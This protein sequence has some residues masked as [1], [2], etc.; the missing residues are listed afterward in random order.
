MRTRFVGKVLH[1]MSENQ[2]ADRPGGRLH[3]FGPSDWLNWLKAGYLPMQSGTPL[4]YPFAQF[5]RWQLERQQQR[6]VSEEAM[7][8]EWQR[9][10]EA[11]PE[12]VRG[13]LSFEHFR[14]QGGSIEADIRAA[15]RRHQGGE[16]P[17]YDNGWQGQGR[18]LRLFASPVCYAGWR[19]LAQGFSGLAVALNSAHKSLA[20]TKER[21]SLLAPVRY[22]QAHRFK[23]SADN[24]FPGLLE[25]HAS[26]A[27][28]QEWRL[29]MP[30]KTTPQHRDKPALPLARDLVRAIYWSVAT[31]DEVV[32]G[33]RALKRDMRFRSVELGCITPDAHRWQLQ[34]DPD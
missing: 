2:Q 15:A 30:A 21:P 17:H 9:Q 12:A 26:Q 29:L 10:Y 28:N 22:G 13:L 32:E 20:S 14:A 33:I 1:P 6:P 24:P 23:V 4:A 18:L 7:E 11:L 31:P 5:D 8:E 16:Q 27:D 25:D 3:A 19:D 34:I